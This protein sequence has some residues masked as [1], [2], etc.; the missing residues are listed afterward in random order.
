MRSTLF[1]LS[2]I[3]RLPLPMLSIGLLVHAERLTGSFAAAG[4]VSAVFAA[5]LGVGGPLLGRVV[6]RR[7]H[8]P[9][10]VPAAIVAGAALAATAALPEGAPVW[11][12][13]ALAAVLGLSVPPVGASLRTLLPGLVG[14]SAVQAAYATE[15]TAVELTFVAGPP[16][17]LLAGAVWST[18]AAL[19]AAGVLLVVATIAFAAH[20]DVRAW[21]PAPVARRPRAGSLHSAGMRTLVLALL[22]VGVAFGAVEVAVAAAADELG[23]TA[24]AGPLLGVWGAGSLAGG[25]VS[26]RRRTASLPGLLAALAV[27]H[28]ALAAATG[29]VIALA[30]VLALAGATI[31]PTYASIYAMVEDVAPAGTVTEAFAWLATAVAIGAAA[32]AAFAGALAAAAGPATT[33][34]LAGGAG[35]LAALVVLARAEALDVCVQPAG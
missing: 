6:D 34:V 8:A 7:G 25:I 4:V 1:G 24:A 11:G 32:G 10:L 27:G 18:G 22:A 30:G 28:L 17:V 26:A 21:R 35:A 2:I 9:V 15:A 20:R 23:A 29:S 31:A 14:E 33:F 12:L 3:A 16:L 13:V 19:G 5:A